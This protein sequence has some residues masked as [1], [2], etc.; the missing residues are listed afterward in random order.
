MIS[1]KLRPNA[2]SSFQKQPAKSIK[3]S[4]HSVS[5]SQSSVMVLDKKLINFKDPQ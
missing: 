3:I 5:G 4:H 2:Q 1:S